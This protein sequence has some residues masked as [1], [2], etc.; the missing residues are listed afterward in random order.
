MHIC[1]SGRVDEDF[2]LAHVC[3]HISD[4]GIPSG[5]YH[6]GGDLYILGYLDHFC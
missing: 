5:I 3:P 4:Q 1:H 6:L 2:D